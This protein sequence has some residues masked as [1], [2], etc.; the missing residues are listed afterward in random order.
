MKPLRLHPLPAQAQDI[1]QRLNVPPRLEAHLKLVHDVAVRLLDGVLGKWPGLPINREFIL[2]GASLH[3]VGKVIHSVEL[4]GAGKQHEAAGEI[5]LLR[6]GVRAEVARFARTHGA[7][8]EGMLLEDLLVRTADTIWRG[9][10][11]DDLESALV[12]ILAVQTGDEAY[13]LFG[14]LDELL[15]KLAMDAGRRLDWQQAY[16]SRRRG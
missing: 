9:S 4:T 15:T 10:R 6:L 16:V 2:I 11:D 3:D 12:R 1:L 8:A 7:P 5:L 14:Y 13:L